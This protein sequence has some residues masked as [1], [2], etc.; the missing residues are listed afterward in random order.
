MNENEKP[1]LG[2]TEAAVLTVVELIA[3]AAQM[4]EQH[5]SYW[6][7]LYYQVRFKHEA[8]EIY[9]ELT[10]RTAGPDPVMARLD[11]LEKKIDEL[12]NG[13]TLKMDVR[14]VHPAP[15]RTAEDVIRIRPEDLAA[16]QDPAA[17]G[18]REWHSFVPP[19]PPDHY[20]PA[21][22]RPAGRK[23]PEDLAAE[24][25][26]AAEGP[27]EW[28]SFVPPTP[29][30][31]YPPAPPRPAG[32]IKPEDLTSDQDPAAAF[33]KQFAEADE[34]NTSSDAARH[35]PLEGKAEEDPTPV[36]R[37][38]ETIKLQE[39]AKSESRS[40]AVK[41]QKA[42]EREFKIRVA[43]RLRE[44]RTHGVKVGDIVTASCG[45]VPDGAVLT[46][47]DGGFRPIADYRALD[48]AL[49]QLAV[50]K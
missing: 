9:G 46:I 37:G 18:P 29:P 30:D 43:E 11:E 21:P 4:S 41:K 23:E 47:L 16:E 14:P 20:P 40:E 33:I 44:A 45:A 28:H 3:R 15:Y 31:H 36:M 7:D 13:V 39:R 17:E 8:A 1:A 32:R 34:G 27:R 26:P 2:S 24:Q 42:A 50:E 48:A 49:D 10:E 38:R 6:L 22:P 5:V 25:D 19:T 12:K 35:L